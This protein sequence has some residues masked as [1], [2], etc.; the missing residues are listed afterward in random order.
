VEEPCVPCD[1][2]VVNDPDPLSLHEGKTDEVATTMDH[3]SGIADIHPVRYQNQTIAEGG[4]KETSAIGSI[5][6][7][8]DKEL[9]RTLRS[10]GESMVENIQVTLLDKAKKRN[11]LPNRYHVYRYTLFF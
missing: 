9:T 3:T 2:N 4:Q 7:V 5:S 8:S 10:L 1:D 11:L 6:N